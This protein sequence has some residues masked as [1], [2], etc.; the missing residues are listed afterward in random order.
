MDLAHGDAV[1][2]DGLAAFGVGQNVGGV[3]KPRVP[4]TADG[5]AVLVGDKYSLAEKGLM[6]PCLHDSFSVGAD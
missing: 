2:D 4:K 5:A 3:E 1:G 6:Q